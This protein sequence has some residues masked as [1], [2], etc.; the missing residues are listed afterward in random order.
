M[1]TT[2]EKRRLEPWSDLDLSREKCLPNKREVSRDTE[3]GEILLGW[4]GRGTSKL[5]PVH[6]RLWS[7]SQHSKSIETK[8]PTGIGKTP[9]FVGAG[10]SFQGKSKYRVLLEEIRV[11]D[12]LKEISEFA[13]LESNWDLEDALAI[14]P[15]AAALAAK[16]VLLVDLAARRRGYRWQEP[17]VGPDPDGGIDLVWNGGSR[18]IILM[19]R[20]G[21]P[22]TVECIIKSTDTKPVR[23]T[24]SISDAVARV[25]WA[26][27]K[28]V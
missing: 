22:D 11:L 18:R 17:V 10:A 13:T 3:A 1:A 25:L 5:C 19:T 4:P 12:A 16:L 15:G 23:T 2:I 9:L 8:A 27:E 7:E 26:L 20:P 14:D 6:P 21:Q 24:L 28:S